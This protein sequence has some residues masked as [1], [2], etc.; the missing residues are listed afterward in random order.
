MQLTLT[1]IGNV[2][3][4]TTGFLK[5]V[6]SHSV[7]PYRGCAFGN[8]LCGVACYVRQNGHV[9]QGRNWGDFLEVRQNAAD[10]YLKHVARERA[11]A[12]RSRAEFA[13]FLSSSTEPFLP[14]EFRYGV[15]R[16]LL[17]AMLHEPPDLL[18]LQTHTHKVTEYLPLYRELAARCRLRVHIS[19]ETDRENLPGLPPHA[20]SVEQR[21]TAAAQLKEADL[22][23]VVT[24]SPLLPIASPEGF[25]A[26]VAEVANAVVL[27][28]F[29]QGDG[30][31]D[32][33]RT[34]RTVLPSAIA[35][36]DPASVSLDYRLAMETVARRFL[37]GRV[38][39]NIDGFAGRYS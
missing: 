19:I 11:W 38:G 31:P 21:L 24:V 2:L 7:Q 28:H 17:E 30:T 23:T 29:I 25:F 35:A 26:R 27:D 39:V 12:R 14:Q 9:T 18:I 10:S 16:S 8:A 36:I 6:S 32:G 34:M 20:S 3:T 1:E 37:P 13:I 5:T 4:R 15:T 33:A 22:N